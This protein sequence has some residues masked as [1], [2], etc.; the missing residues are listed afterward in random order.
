MAP[1][2]QE[3]TFLILAALAAEPLYGYA[4]IQAVGELSAG[5]VELRAGTLYPALD[6]LTTDGLIDV[7]REEIVDGRLRRYYQLTDA[8]VGRLATEVA[9]QR[10]NVEAAEQRLAART[11]D[12][13]DRQR[14]TFKPREA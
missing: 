10:R 14:R 5:Q 4:I 13:A 9:R 8:G 3:P 1:P 11:A 12:A 2:L 6:R 7:A